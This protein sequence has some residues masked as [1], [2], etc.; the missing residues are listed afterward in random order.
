MLGLS[1]AL[2]HNVKKLY[3]ILED[4]NV[5]ITKHYVNFSFFFFLLISRA[6]IINQTALHSNSQAVPCK[7]LFPSGWR[8]GVGLEV[9]R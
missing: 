3:Y 1:S 7:T 4:S 8:A 9:G 6:L 5:Y 2:L